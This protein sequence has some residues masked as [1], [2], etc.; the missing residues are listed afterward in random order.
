MYRYTLLFCLCFA[1][2]CSRVN[3][4]YLV[5]FEG[6]GE[7]KAG[8]ASGNVSL[9]GINW[10][11]TEALIGTA[12]ND[13]KN[14]SRSLRLRGYPASAAT[15]QGDKANGLGVLS[16]EYRRFGTDA[17]V[18]WQA[19]YSDDA[20]VSWNNIGSTFTASATVQTF[21]ETVNV[22]GN[23]RIRFIHSSGGVAGTDRR[24]NIDDISLTDFVTAPTL[25]LSADT[26]SGF[27]YR[28][29]QGPSLVQTFTASGLN[30]LGNATLLAP[31]DYEI[32][33]DTNSAFTSSITLVPTAGVVAPTDIFVRLKAGLPVGEY[34][35]SPLTYTTSG[36][37]PDTILLNGKVLGGRAHLT[38]VMINA[39]AS[40]GR[41][42]YLAYRNIGTPLI[43][44][45]ENIDIRYGTTSPA[46]TQFTN[47]IVAAG[48]QA[49]VDS[50]NALLA[51]GCDFVFVN[52]EVGSTIPPS[53]RFI[54]TRFDADYYPDY[55]S[56]C[57][58]SLDSVYFV[59]SNSGNW[60]ASGNFSNSSPLDRYF[61]SIIY[62]DT[63]DFFYVPDLLSGSDGDFITL[64]ESGGAPSAYLNYPACQPNNLSVLPVELLNFEVKKFGQSVVLNW[65]TATELNNDFFRVMR[66]RNAVEWD[67]LGIIPG[68]GNSNVPI[69]YEYVD[70]APLSGTNY[71]RL[72]QVDFDGTTTYLPIADVDFMESDLQVIVF[73]NPINDQLTI[74]GLS[75]DFS[76]ITIINGIGQ[77]V[78]EVNLR[79]PTES[80]L[81]IDARNWAKG[82]YVILIQ[83]QFGTIARKVIK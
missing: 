46:S 73:P 12:T 27:K 57:G 10:N 67:L 71:Y 7:T 3:A 70:K 61:R 53:K 2:L 43:V 38:G 29:D 26:L 5:D 59:F 30:L 32:T 64:P 76:V 16:F 50:L 47:S 36:G 66:S 75:E 33:L 51:S 68:S 44:R 1:G 78:Q 52:A 60:N 25:T 72:H 34:F 81:Q 13:F 58:Q 80:V 62:E 79:L 14:G 4:Q 49:Y 19:Q 17:Q 63:I 21:T 15:M 69:S 20:G 8:Y 6:A 40:E 56:W 41:N 65:T 23:V 45:P 82:A 35:S 77:K 31:A 74:S 18:T 37:N 28:I 55:S 48:N 39:C 9:S 42:E 11:L 83:N 54:V 24:I 22:T